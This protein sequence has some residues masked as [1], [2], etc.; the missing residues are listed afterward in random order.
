MAKVKNFFLKVGR[1]FKNHAPSK[2]R[3]IQL[4]AALLTNANIKGFVHG[5]IYTGATKNACVPGLNCYSCPGAVGACPLGALQDSLA[6]TDKRA[7]FYILGILALFGLL[8]ARTICGFFCPVG[9]GQELLY[10]VKTP[11]VKKSRFTRLLSYL[12]YVFLVVLVIAIPLIYNG[13]P[14]FCK[15]IC[16][17]GT[18]EGG[19]LL[20]WHSGNTDFYDSLGYLFTWKFALLVIFVILCIFFYRFFCRFICPLGAIYG[21]FNRIALIGVK[22]DRDKCVDCGLCLQTCKMDIKHVGDHECINCGDCIPACPTKAITWKGSKIFLHGISEEPE[23]DELKPLASLA[24]VG[25]ASAVTAQTT[26]ADKENVSESTLNAAVTEN[27]SVSG[28]EEENAA[29]AGVE[30]VK[31]TA[32]EIYEKRVK[33]RAF[34]LQFAAWAVA[35]AVLATALVYYNFV[36]KISFNT[37]YDVGDTCPDFTLSRIYDTPAAYNENGE[38][39]E[40]FTLSDYKGK[41]VVLNFWYTTCDPCK[42]ELPHFDK[43]QKD[44]GSAVT[45]VVIHS[46]N[47]QFNSTPATVQGTINHELNGAE[48]SLIFTHDE[49]EI[50][51][52]EMLGGKN[53]FPRTIIIDGDGVITFTRTNSLDEATLRSEIDKALNK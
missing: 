49:L 43:V 9:L 10:K 46:V 35:L 13:I 16:P 19:V 34:W 33:K 22:L 39:L 18:S 11:K 26:V 2:R 6:Q 40:K 47:S 44:Y 14:A 29:E 50:N 52:I 31:P 21:F 5:R 28:K 53:A 15:Y 27:V 32:H 48:S 37:T 7:P 23:T 45:T 8:F 12:K 51:C 36:D 17:A 25:G 42:A 3:L 24:A 4:Y 38:K 30:E 20:L 1:W 41:V